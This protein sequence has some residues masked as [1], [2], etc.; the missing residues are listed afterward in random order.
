MFLVLVGIVMLLPGLCAI[1]LVAIDWKGALS[2]SF[3]P[4]LLLCLA[5]S[6]GGIV[7]IRAVVKGPRS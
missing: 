3:L 1:I 6:F 5:V 4:I 7:L 2:S